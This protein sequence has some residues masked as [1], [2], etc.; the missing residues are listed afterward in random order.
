MTIIEP[1]AGLYFDPEKLANP[2]SIT[3]PPPMFITEKE[4]VRYYAQH[5]LNVIRLHAGIN[6][7]TDNDSNN[8]TSRAVKYL[9]RWREQ[10]DLLLADTPAVYALEHSGPGQKP[11]TSLLVRLPISSKN[12]LPQPEDSAAPDVSIAPFLNNLNLSII[13]IPLVYADPSRGVETILK[14]QINSMSPLIKADGCQLWPI[15]DPAIV[16]RLKKRFQGLSLLPIAALEIYAAQIAYAAQSKSYPGMLAILDNN[17]DL[18]QDINDHSTLQ[19]AGSSYFRS[20][21]V[22]LVMD[23]W[24]K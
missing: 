10:K 6:F 21:P 14:S 15:I 22:G 18:N 17:L 1:L 24:G 4:Q 9:Q 16:G 20:I 5:P 13:P 19:P 23:Y 11:I 12:N 8:P 7:P 3:T 2:L